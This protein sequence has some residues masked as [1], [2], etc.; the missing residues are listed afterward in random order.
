MTTLT[1]SQRHVAA[2]VSSGLP[3]PT[4][5]P[6]ATATS[7][8]STT[9]V[10]TDQNTAPPSPKPRVGSNDH[11]SPEGMYHANATADARIAAPPSTTLFDPARRPATAP[12]HRMPIAAHRSMMPIWVNTQALKGKVW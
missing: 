10:V 1:T 2:M 7:A 4:L 5:T 8:V 9:P 3:R 6:R 12:P 11:S